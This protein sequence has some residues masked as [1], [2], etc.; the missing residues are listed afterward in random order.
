M[1]T[2]QERQFNDILVGLADELD[3]PP[4]K[5]KQAVDRYSTVGN[6]T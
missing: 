1:L 5:Y 4:S 2:E 3:I 6:W